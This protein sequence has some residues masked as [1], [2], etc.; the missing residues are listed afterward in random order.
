V[1]GGVV[2]VL[3]QLFADED[4]VFEV[5]TA[6]GNEGHQ[7]VAAEAEFTAVRAGTS[8]STCP[9]FQRGR[10]RASGFW[11]MQSVLVGAL[12]L[13]QGINGSAPT[14]RLSTP[15]WSLFDAHDDALG[16]DLIH[17]AVALAEHDSAGIAGR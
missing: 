13:G 14:S 8:A 17:D 12:E 15:E 10:T 4:G 2:I 3:H 11:L 6:P 16:V 1:D 9:F 7:D 5:V